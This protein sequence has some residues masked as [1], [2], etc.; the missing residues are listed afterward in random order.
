MQINSIVIVGGGSAGW[1][2]ATSLSKHLPEIDVTLI[3]SPDVPPVG[4]GE[5]ATLHL[6]EWLHALG[7]KDEDWMTQ[8]NAVYKGS[9][10]FTDFYKKGETF[11]Y[12]FGAQDFSLTEF[13]TDAWFLKKWM[14]PDTPQTDFAESFWP[15][16]QM[17]NKNKIHSNEDGNIPFFSILTDFSYQFDVGKLGKW[18]KTNRCTKVKYILDHVA[19]VN[20]DERGW[21]SSL[22]TK[23]HGELEADLYIDCTGFSSILLEKSLGVP[24][25][26]YEDMLI[27]NKTWV[28][29]I[30]YVNPNVEIDLTTNGTAIN[31]GWS[32][33]I[34]LWDSISKGYVYSEKFINKE[35]ALKEFKE[36]LNNTNLWCKD[37]DAEELEYRHIDIRNGVHEKA[38]H[39]NCLAIGLS[40]GFIEPLESTGLVFVLGG[41]D[42]LIATLQTKDR[43][44]NQFDRNCVNRAIRIQIDMSKYFVAYHFYG[45]DR[46]DTEYWRWYSQEL[47]TS[48]LYEGSD[49][50]STLGNHTDEALDIPGMR[51]GYAPGF[52]FSNDGW[53][54]IMVG[55]HLNLVSSAR[56]KSGELDSIWARKTENVINYWKE[57]NT[58]ISLLADK[59]PTHYE[60]LKEKIYNK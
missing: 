50:D 18:L 10:K 37:N 35:I 3:E 5:S 57:R 17:L 23:K 16:M 6:N 14:Y 41:I 28:T 56:V 2:T 21:I 32:W 26:S 11:H 9:I 27:N 53:A 8:C 44:V 22:S 12:P 45:T 4:V 36:H 49:S 39:K 60:H 13:G 15:N 20:L 25:S 40:Y 52:Q 54:C 38:W 43:L 31:N 46:D 29:K 58:K 59:S 51:F 47:D 24:H 19:N 55:H 30:P 42:R 48:Q 34:P 33:N 7:I 1:M